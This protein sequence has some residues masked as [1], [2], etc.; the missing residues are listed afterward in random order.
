[1]ARI[2]VA[3]DEEQLRSMLAFKLTTLGH[4]LVG[5]ADGEEA[6]A[7]AAAHRLD[8]IV[9]DIA[10]PLLNGLDVLRRLKADPALRSIPVIILS[11]KAR[12][13]DIRAGLQAGAADYVVKP[14]SLKD[15]A[16]R[17]DRALGDH[18]GAAESSVN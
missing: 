13:H 10:M 6:V 17:I 18:R 8:L 16:A 15:L 7:M 2:M 3:E 12:E 4:Q 14:F 11:A 9:L 1:M 5:A